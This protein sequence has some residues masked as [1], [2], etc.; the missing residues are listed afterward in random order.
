MEKIMRTVIIHGSIVEKE[1]PPLYGRGIFVRQDVPLPA[2]G[3]RVTVR[4]VNNDQ[5]FFGKVVAVN[6]ETRT[7]DIRL[8]TKIGRLG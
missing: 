5:H 6:L 8:F 2:V 4:G 7:Y 1:F 3:E